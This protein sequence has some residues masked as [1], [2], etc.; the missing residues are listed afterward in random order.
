MIDSTSGSQ[1]AVNPSGKRR[2]IERGILGTACALVLGVYAYTAH[3]GFVTE[4]LNPVDNYYNLLVQG[5]GAGQLNLK[6]EVPPGFARLANPYDPVENAPYRYAPYRMLDLSYYKG[7]LYLYFGVTPALLLFWPY[8]V[9]SGG[10]LSYGQAGVIF[11]S[12][13]FLITVYLLNALWRRYFAEVGVWVVA[14]GTVALGLAAAVPVLL[15]RCDV[16]EVAVACGYALTM[17]AVLAIWKALHELESGKRSGWIA[18][19]SLAYGL[20]VAARPSLLLGAVILLAPVVEAWRK[21]RKICVSLLAVIVPIGLIGLGLGIY[22][23]LRF[24]SVFETG[25]RYQLVGHRRLIWQAFSLRYLWFNF[26]VYFL[27]PAR[28]S[29]RFPFAHGIHVPPLPVGHRPV[30]QA[31]GIL[32]NV[33]VVWLALGV[34]LAWRGR[35]VEAKARLRVFLATAAVVF[36]IG[37]LTLV[38]YYYAAGRFEVEFLPEL[39]LLAVI[40]I[41]G[42]ERA[43]LTQPVWRRAARWSWGVLLALSVVFNVLASVEG[44]GKVYND[45]GVALAHVGRLEEA[46]P[47]YEEALRLKPDYAEAQYNLG[48]ALAR[49]GRRP[50]AIEHWERALQI[51]PDLADAHNNLAVALMGQ[52]KLREAIGHL[53]QAVRIRPNNPEIRYNLGNALGEMGRRQEAIEQYEEALRLRPDFAEARRALERGQG[54]P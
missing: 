48:V 33:P 27:Q 51:Q 26:Q 18:G 28:W 22:N 53:E 8:V 11:C 37:A 1:E 2:W 21:R 31:F 20:A 52:G 29:S 36:G 32:A 19:A 50:E 12:V 54:V 41:L 3:S 13:G 5:F 25:F 44:C 9:L 45:L 15:A 35:S 38:L 34:P 10:Y 6:K 46:I 7:K 39:I 40:G 14:A 30:E 24:D 17:L 42:L 16:Y 49:V 4:S 43:V 23:W 47:A